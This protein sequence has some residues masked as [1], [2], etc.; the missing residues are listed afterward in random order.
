[1]TVSCSS[2]LRVISSNGRA[3]ASWAWP[4]RQRRRSGRQPSFTRT[5]CS[6][7]G[8]TSPTSSPKA[9]PRG[10]CR[11]QSC[12]RMLSAGS[13]PGMARAAARS[14]RRRVH[15]KAHH[16][17]KDL[18]VDDVNHPD[19][20][21]RADH[22]DEKPYLPFLAALSLADNPALHRGDP[23]DDQ[24]EAYRDGLVETLVEDGVAVSLRS[25]EGLE[26]VEQQQVN[27]DQ[28][29]ERVG[30]ALDRLPVFPE[31]SL[32][33]GIGRRQDRDAHQDDQEPR[34]QEGM[35]GEPAENAPGEVGRNGR[36]GR[37]RDSYQHEHDAVPAPQGREPPGSGYGNKR[38]NRHSQ[39]EGYLTPGPEY[40]G[41]GICQA[42][43]FVQREPA[44]GHEDPRDERGQPEQEQDQGLLLDN[45]GREYEVLAHPAIYGPGLRG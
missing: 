38:G 27:D 10:F 21:R 23:E 41:L 11:R 31:P 45:Q 12:R 44:A 36:S 39:E 20:I 43:L 6:T 40:V 3:C 35:P 1:M 24:R 2:T 14:V 8:P 5:S 22:R 16:S 34:Y 32:R 13:H 25:L 4:R 30:H 17:G 37:V 28:R 29:P 26:S 18:F 19:D 42:V 9:R 15:R 33:R 7:P